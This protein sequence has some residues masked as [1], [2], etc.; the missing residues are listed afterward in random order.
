MFY[1]RHGGDHR[2]PHHRYL[3][4]ET[5]ML[6]LRV[7]DTSETPGRVTKVE[8]EDQMVVEAFGKKLE[9]SRIK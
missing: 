2:Q 1:I 6:R 4:G 5:V 7:D 3:V 8:S 9:L